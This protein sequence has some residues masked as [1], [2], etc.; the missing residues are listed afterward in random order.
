MVSNKKSVKNGNR[1]IQI[2][3]LAHWKKALNKGYDKYI[4]ILRW[5][6]GSRVSNGSKSSFS[7]F[8]L[9]EDFE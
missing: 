9:C 6:V 2:L 7:Y 1:K 5:G 4:D 3:D 8:L